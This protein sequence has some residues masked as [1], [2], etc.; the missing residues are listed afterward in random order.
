M[1]FDP[2]IVGLFVG[3][4]SAIGTL[5]VIGVIAAVSE[6]RQQKRDAAERERLLHTTVRLDG[7]ALRRAG[8]QRGGL[9]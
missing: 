5:G 4:I 2:F 7:E 6:K 3:F 1:T 9:S 8:R